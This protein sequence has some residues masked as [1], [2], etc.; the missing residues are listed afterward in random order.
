V[1]LLANANLSESLPALSGIFNGQYND[2][3]YDWFEDVGG[4][5]VTSMIINAFCPIIEFWV[6]CILYWFQKRVD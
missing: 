1:L 4:I 3:N 5:L 6:E 2:Y